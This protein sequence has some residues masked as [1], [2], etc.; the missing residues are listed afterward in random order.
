MFFVPSPELNEGSRPGH[1]LYGPPSVD[2]IA[3]HVGDGS[4]P[5]TR[6]AHR[7]H[8]AKAAAQGAVEIFGKS[9]RKKK[10]VEGGILKKG[11]DLSWFRA[12]SKEFIR[13]IDDYFRNK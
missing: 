5:V 2:H 11:W 13:S 12:N 1:R 4:L 3:G 6:S 10:L 7:R 9:D 8:A